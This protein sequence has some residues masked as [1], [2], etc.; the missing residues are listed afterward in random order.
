MDRSVRFRRK[1]KRRNT[2]VINSHLIRAII[3]EEID[4]PMNALLYDYARDL[5][6]DDLDW[7]GEKILDDPDLWMCLTDTIIS[8]T[9]S[10]RF[11]DLLEEAGLEPE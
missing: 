5:P 2:L 9:V 10:L 6:D 7:L 8:H 3:A 4:F 11:T 1:P